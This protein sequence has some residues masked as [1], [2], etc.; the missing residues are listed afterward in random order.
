M[1]RLIDDVAANWRRLDERIEGV[2]AEIKIQAGAM[3]LLSFVDS[4]A[5][6]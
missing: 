1:V 6:A 5:G 3:A 2:A 4:T